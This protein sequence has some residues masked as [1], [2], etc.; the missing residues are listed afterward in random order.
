MQFAQS[1]CRHKQTSSTSNLCTTGHV[2]RNMQTTTELRYSN[3]SKHS[4]TFHCHIT[5]T[6]NHK[7]Y[8]AKR[9]CCCWCYYY[10]WILFNCQVFN[11]YFRLWFRLG[12]M[13][14][15]GTVLDLINEVSIRWIQFEKRWVTNNRQHK[16][17][18]Y[19]IS[20]PSQLSQ[21]IPPWVC[22]RSTSK[23]WVLNRHITWYFNILLRELILN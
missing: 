21:A 1:P 20:H 16:P 3:I 17:S 2:L 13:A 23:I 5:A 10:F 15:C 11:S 9:A 12:L 22:T 18:Q 6:N 14:V 8:T 7:I 19:V 4:A